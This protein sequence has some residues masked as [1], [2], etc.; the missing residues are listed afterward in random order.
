MI[1]EIGETAGKIWDLLN[2][3]GE[4]SLAQI[5]KNIDGSADHINQSL[6]WL[7][8]EDKLSIVKNGN[9]LRVSLK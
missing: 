1:K 6:G 7:A 5:K 8:R 4:V 9:S 3:S 2:N